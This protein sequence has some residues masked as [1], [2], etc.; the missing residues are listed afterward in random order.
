MR[1]WTNERWI[2]M[3]TRRTVNWQMLSFEAQGL[4]DQLMK[5]VDSVG[6]LELGRYGRRGVA[7]A[8][9]HQHRWRDLEAPLQELLDDG[10]VQLVGEA[11]WIPNFLAA[12]EAR[13]SDAQRQRDL[14]ERRASELK[15]KSLGLVG[16]VTK[17]DK[18]SR[19]VTFGHETSPN[20]HAVSQGVTPRRERLEEIR[21]V[22]IKGGRSS[23]LRVD[24]AAAKKKRT[25]PK[26]PDLPDLP[27][28]RSGR[29]LDRAT[30]LFALVADGVR[31]AGKAYLSEQLRKTSWPLGI[32]DDRLEL[33][34]KDE[35]ALEWA[36]ENLELVALDALRLAEPD[37]AISF[38]IAERPP[39]KTKWTRDECLAALVQAGLNESPAPKEE[40]LD[41]F[42]NKAKELAPQVVLTAAEHFLGDPYWK[43]SG[44]ALA[45]F[46]S[47]G[48]WRPRIAGR[49]QER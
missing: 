26:K 35:Y 46:I 2:K 25:N 3:Y 4:F 21:L 36:T 44:W 49:Q 19:N 28:K 40:N 8:I 5:V 30:E 43:K 10:C 14:R 29:E 34:V 1:D 41:R 11:L 9:G 23:K 31:E 12:Q 48:V 45:V 13:T 42:W 20:R 16:S 7:V 17:R 37:L 24:V 39:A 33:G 18:A 15:A 38:R 27:A 22:G 32:I 47:E 6:L